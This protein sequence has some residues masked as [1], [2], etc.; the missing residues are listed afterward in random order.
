MEKTVLKLTNEEK[1]SFWIW[2]IGKKLLF[3]LDGGFDGVSLSYSN[4]GIGSQQSAVMG[5]LFIAGFCILLSFFGVF[6]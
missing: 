3:L 1:Q 5:V 4:G 6:S 2:S